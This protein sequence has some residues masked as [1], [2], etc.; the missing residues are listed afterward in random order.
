LIALSGW[1][2]DETMYR[3]MIQA[4]PKNPDG[5]LG[6]ALV[7]IGQRKDRTALAALDQAAA[8]DSTRYEIATHHAAI[9]ARYREWPEVIRW[10]RL[11]RARGATEADSWLLEVAALQSLQR[12]DEAGQVLDTLM[13]IQKSDPDV[14]AAYGR[15]KLLQNRPQQAVK[16]LEYA[17]S[18]NPND[19]SLALL[20]GDAYAR[21]K[22]YDRARAE[23]KR[24]IGLD[25]GNVD[26]WL[27]LAVVCH[28]MLDIQGRDE[29]LNNA[30]NLP[31]SDPA[32]IQEM[33]KKMAG[34]GDD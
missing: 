5:Y 22:S 3:M 30:A 20:L 10:A 28:L 9:A 8:L 25:P 17:A 7:K 23:I 34:V 33:W 16:P 32:K 13:A 15:Q 21:V 29:A 6:L 1:R 18:W 12:L 14:A 24:A 27:R 19:P 26:A 2:S 31:G 4:Q 11:A